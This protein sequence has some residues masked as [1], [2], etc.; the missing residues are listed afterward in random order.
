MKIFDKLKAGGAPRPNVKGIDL[1]EE[2][3]EEEE[4]ELGLPGN[5]VGNP[6]RPSY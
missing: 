4:E 6:K 2:E 1:E 5:P 3:E